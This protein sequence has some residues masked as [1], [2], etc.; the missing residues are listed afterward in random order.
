M[1]EVLQMVLARGSAW[2]RGF[3]FDWKGPVRPK[4]PPPQ[5]IHVLSLLAATLVAQHNSPASD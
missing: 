2:L 1:G 4:G 5:R 3:D